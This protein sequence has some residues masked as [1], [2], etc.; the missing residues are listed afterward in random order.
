MKK[1]TL[2]QQSRAIKEIAAELASPSLTAKELK[3]WE[4][5]QAAAVTLN[6]VALIGENK[7]LLADELYRAAK[8]YLET[9]GG[10][11]FQTL[12]AVVKRIEDE[13]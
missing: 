10:R 12:R 9:E 2:R 3:T 4:A 7:V 5:A 6:A 11:D 1:Y 13:N 8:A